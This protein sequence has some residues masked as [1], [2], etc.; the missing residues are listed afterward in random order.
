[1]AT[2][3]A[4]TPRIVDSPEA[5]LARMTEM[6]QAQQIF[7]TYTQ[8]QVDHIFREVALAINK[9]RIP[10]AKLAVEETG[11]GVLEDKVIKNHFATE[12]TYNYYK[13][14]KT[15]GVV[16]VSYTHLARR[17]APRRKLC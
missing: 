8:E 9:Q 10:L 7:A 1:M 11:M 2:K 3:K 12:Y 16:A 5:L 17:L 14:M 15:C 13:N 6:K 4:Q